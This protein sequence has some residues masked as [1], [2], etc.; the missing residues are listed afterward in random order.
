[1]VFTQCYVDQAKRLARVIYC[2][3]EWLGA[4]DPREPQMR[5]PLI[6]P[7]LFPARAL[8]SS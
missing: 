1:M 8:V 3:L 7:L 6:R 2:H 4:N 5:Q